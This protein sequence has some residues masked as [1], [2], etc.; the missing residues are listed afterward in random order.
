MNERTYQ[1]AHEPT[2]P[3]WWRPGR[4]GARAL[5]VSSLAGFAELIASAATPAAMSA[6]TIRRRSRSSASRPPLARSTARL[7]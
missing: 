4:T 1:L 6:W 2:F 3:T 7:A 5:L